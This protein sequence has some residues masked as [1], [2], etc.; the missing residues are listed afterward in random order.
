[1]LARLDH[2]EYIVWTV[3]IWLNTIFTA[4]YDCTVAHITFKLTEN[5]FEVTNLNR[6]Q[7]PNKW[8]D[9]MGSDS[10]GQF[11]ATHD[12][13]TFQIEIWDL[14]NKTNHRFIHLT[15]KVQLF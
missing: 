15:L 9:A 7:G 8:A 10:T 2:H 11:M 1:M 6:I 4:S 3:K 13:N 14:H 5:N 12:E